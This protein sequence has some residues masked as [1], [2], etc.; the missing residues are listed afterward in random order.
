MK[1]DS[2]KPEQLPIDLQALIEYQ[3]LEEREAIFHKGEAA[4]AM[5]WLESGQIRLLHYTAD[6]Q[7]VNH[8]RV[9]AGESFAEVALFIAS[10]DCT[11]IAESASRIAILPKYLLL[12]AMRQSSDLAELLM[13]QLA[14][15]LHQ[16]KIL[17]ELRSIRSA[18]DRMLQYLLISMQP[19]Q[20]LIKLDQPLRRIAEDLALTPE[21]ISR[22]LAQLENEG[23][24]ARQK[25]SIQVLRRNVAT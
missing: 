19:E 6:G 18:R 25:R 22:A 9:Q 2:F 5:F 23:V 20:S 11:A 13:A 21:A 1:M 3:D 16:A 10:Y 4:Q 15:R 12:Q 24:I 8:Y 7:T 17:L 14:W